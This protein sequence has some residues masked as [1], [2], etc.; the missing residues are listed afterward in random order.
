M[1]ESWLAWDWPTMQITG[2]RN[3]CLIFRKDPTSFFLAHRFPSTAVKIVL[4]SPYCVRRVQRAALIWRLLQLMCAAYLEMKS[5]AN[6]LRICL[7]IIRGIF[8]GNNFRNYFSQSAAS[9]HFML[10]CIHKWII[11]STSSTSLL[12]SKCR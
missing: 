4:S 11:D 3:D 2:K 8:S 6:E 12:I 5:F 7:V 1:R 9:P 10:R